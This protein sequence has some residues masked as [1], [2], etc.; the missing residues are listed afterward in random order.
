METKEPLL[1]SDW[2]IYRGGAIFLQ[3]TEDCLLEDLLL[4]QVGGNAIFVNH[5]NRRAAVR[6]CEIVKAGASGVVFVGDPRAARSPLFNFDRRQTPADLDR[7]PGPKTDNYPAD[8]LR[9]RLPDPPH[10]PRGE[11]DG[12]RGHRPGAEHH[13]PPLFDL[14]HAAGRHQHRR[15]LLGR[16]RDRVVRRF[17]HREGDR[18][19]R[20]LQFLGPR[21][22]LELEDVGMHDLLSREE[23]KDLP[24]LDAVKQNVLRNNRWRCD[25]GWDI[26]L[27]DGSSNYRIYNNLCLN[28][29]MK[30]REGYLRIDENNIMV[31]NGFHAH[32]WL[33]GCQ[34]V[35]RR[36]IFWRTYEMSPAVGK[37][38][39]YNLFQASGVAVPRP[40]KELQK[41]SRLDA[42][43][44]KADAMFVDP[45]HGDYRVK[46]GS[47]ALALGFKNFPMDQ[48]GVTSAK[49]KAKARE[50]VLPGTVA[51]VERKISNPRGIWLGA[52]VRTIEGMEFSIYGVTQ[53]DGGVQ[54]L[55]VPA[56]SPAAQAGLRKDDLIQG[57][58]AYKVSKVED[59]VAAYSAAGEGAV[60]VRFV[61]GQKLQTM[62]L[63]EL[64][65]VLV[66][67][68]NDARGF[69]KL[70]VPSKPAGT[71]TAN[72][73]TANDPLASLTDGKLGTGYGPVFPNGVTDGAYKMDLGSSRP[74]T[75]ITSWSCNQLR[76]GRQTVHLF[77][78]SAASDPG[79]DTADARLF[80]PLGTI[81]TE[82]V[83]VDRFLG[84]SFRA[85]P[86]KTLGAFRW[87]VWKVSPI[88]SLGENTAFQ[89][90]AVETANPPTAEKNG[91]ADASG[92]RNQ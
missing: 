38:V 66:E 85:R 90:L 61:R 62:K 33:R 30:I 68:A 56:G 9:G 51:E 89:E 55:D 53:Q 48:F 6:G 42:L 27:D 21:P 81:D 28:G 24:L 32:V 73:R 14:R 37:E 10:R 70:R 43:S 44:L 60:A 57:L 63:A 17:R 77:G 22:V 41:I 72:R 16:P 69:D 5:Y 39:D 76:R 3:G 46:E 36:N 58:N 12:G 19:P 2:A 40:A 78:S 20:Q 52:T 71:V 31:N 11:A 75:A 35:V 23:T 26:D 13:R 65:F 49:L 15:R 91:S 1:R 34:D 29:G 74:V 4:D 25:H 47:P 79:W 54:L 67:T 18:R 59:L 87:I 50:P 88:S 82:R 45:A 7:T 8:C 83:N 84:A 80:T 64:P 92:G 86:G